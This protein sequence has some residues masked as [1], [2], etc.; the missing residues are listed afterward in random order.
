MMVRFRMLS[1]STAMGDISQVLINQPTLIGYLDNIEDKY[2]PIL[3]KY[4]L[5]PKSTYPVVVYNVDSI[6]GKTRSQLA[7]FNGYELIRNI[8]V[9][10]R[11]L[12]NTP[13]EEWLELVL[14]GVD[15][16]QDYRIRMFA[17][18]F[19]YYY[20]NVIDE[21]MNIMYEDEIASKNIEIYIIYVFTGCLVVLATFINIFGVTQLSRNSKNLYDKT[22]KMFKLLLRGSINDIISK[23]EISVESITETYD[24]SAD[25]KKNKYKNIDRKNVFKTAFKK[26]KGFIINGLLIGSILLLTVPVIIKDKS[27]VS[28]LDYLLLVGKRKDMIINMSIFSFEVIL[29]DGR[30]YVPGLSESYL[31]KEIEKLEKIQQQLYRGELGLQS[32]TKMEHLDDLIINKDCRFD[33]NR[34]ETIEEMPD[35]GFTKNAIKMHL[36]E[37]VDEMIER[38]KVI[39]KSSKLKDF[40]TY[41]HMYKN[42][43]DNT[44]LFMA[45]QSSDF[46]FELVAIEHLFAGLEKFDT[47]L[48]DMLFES[49]RSTMVYLIIIIFVGISLISLA[50]LIIYKMIKSTNENLNE[51]VNLIFI[52]PPSTINMI[53]QFKRFIETGGAD[54]EE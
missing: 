46:Y 3:K 18:N 11:D 34:C 9:W 40:K 31:N 22:M 24:I 20:T 29:Q 39:L 42:I 30:F 1:T 7:H 8:V 19:Q 49:I 28:N 10:G 12:T 17:E 23:F 47:I 43:Y 38:F 16:I 54:E 53:P 5:Q 36:N 2:I 4:S 52:I 15:I 44:R 27:I 14:Q 33:D 32:T 25:N 13:P 41:D 51:L 35:I 21:T 48:Y 50:F 37:F 45:F 6:N 26:L